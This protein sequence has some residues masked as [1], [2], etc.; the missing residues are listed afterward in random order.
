[1]VSDRRPPNPYMIV[2]DFK[3]SQVALNQISS[4]I[5][6]ITVIQLVKAQHLF[7]IS[8]ERS[9]QCG[10]LVIMAEKLTYAHLTIPNF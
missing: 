10:A 7:F 3:K 1:M 5:G 8:L 6:Y 9:G 2:S 4:T